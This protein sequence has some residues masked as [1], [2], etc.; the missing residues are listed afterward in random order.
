MEAN[1]YSHPNLEHLGQ[2]VKEFES[3]VAKNENK[4]KQHKF[5][6]ENKILTS[7]ERPAK[8]NA[9]NQGSKAIEFECSRSHQP[10]R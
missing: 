10:F 6:V 4:Q 8:S 5:S 9:S 1:E 7:R 3:I 2:T